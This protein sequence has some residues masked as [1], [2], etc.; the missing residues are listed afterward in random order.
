VPF[1]I[2]FDFNQLDTEKSVNRFDSS[3]P[4]VSLFK[5]Q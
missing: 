4:A 5:K 3:K 2:F 1:L